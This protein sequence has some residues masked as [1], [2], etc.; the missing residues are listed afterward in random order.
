MFVLRNTTFTIKC[1]LSRLSAAT[2]RS[3]LRPKARWSRS[4]SANSA[5]SISSWRIIRK[6]SDHPAHVLFRTFQRRFD[7][8]EEVL[9]SVIF[10]SDVLLIIRWDWCTLKCIKW[11][12]LFNYS[13]ISIPEVL[14]FTVRLLE[15]K[16][17]Q[18]HCS[19]LPWHNIFNNSLYTSV[20]SSFSVVLCDIWIYT[21]IY[22][23]V[24]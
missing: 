6:V 4:Y 9:E 13:I 12:L 10:G 5:T 2:I 14:Q 15:G 3:S 7:T 19:V 20:N 1:V 16:T 8:V 18:P 23:V 22:E 24:M 17:C 11:W 21:N